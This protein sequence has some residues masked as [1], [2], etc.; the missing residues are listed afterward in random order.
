MTERLQNKTHVCGRDQREKVVEGISHWTSQSKGFIYSPMSC[1]CNFLY[2]SLVRDSCLLL[3]TL[4]NLLQSVCVFL[5]HTAYTLPVFCLNRACQSVCRCLSVSARACV[6]VTQHLA[7]LRSF[8]G[9]PLRT[10]DHR[11]NYKTMSRWKLPPT[12]V[13]RNTPATPLRSFS[14]LPPP[15]S[16]CFSPPPANRH[17]SQCVMSAGHT[18]SREAALGNKGNGVQPGR[19]GQRWEDE[20]KRR[21]WEIGK[22]G[23]GGVN[24]C[25]IIPLIVYGSFYCA[26]SVLPQ[27]KW[28]SNPSKLMSETLDWRISLGVQKAHNLYDQI[29]IC[30][31]VGIDWRLV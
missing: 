14:C 15:A 3:I 25:K 23:R 27:W 26:A 17:R 12:A 29:W 31:L 7:S 30:L 20:R 8:T 9:A 28:K 2:P 5:L 6:W 11:D 4:R 13:R 22:G 19:D 10:E 21:G 18:H 16:L 24:E 1:G